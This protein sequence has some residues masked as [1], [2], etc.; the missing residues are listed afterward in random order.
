MDDTCPDCGVKPG[1]THDHGCD[2]ERCPLCEM[3]LIGCNC[4]YKVNG[5]N[6]DTLEVEHPEIYG[7]GPTDEMYVKFDEEVRKKGG[8]LPWTGE[9]PGVA[10]CRE[11]GWFCQDGFGP[12]S[13]Y[14]SFCPC[15]PDAPDAMADLNRLVHFKA[16][17]RDD[18]YDGCTRV[19]R[20]KAVPPGV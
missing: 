15:P 8:F 5:M 16:T 4:I 13:R 6:P 9:W 11:R 12:D 19:P 18:L 1:E 10:E 3:Q 20:T 17:G 14:G 7:S 2:V